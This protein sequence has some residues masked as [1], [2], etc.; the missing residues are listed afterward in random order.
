VP[1]RVDLFIMRGRVRW[2][3]LLFVCCPRRDNCTHTREKENALQ[4]LKLDV[5]CLRSLAAAA[6]AA[7]CMCVIMLSPADTPPYYVF[8]ESRPILYLSAPPPAAASISDLEFLLGRR[9]IFYGQLNSSC[10]RGFNKWR[11][12]SKFMTPRRTSVEERRSHNNH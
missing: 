9:S 3:L 4:I 8:I 11:A 2:L 1:A 7:L 10:C 12:A 6:A 5:V